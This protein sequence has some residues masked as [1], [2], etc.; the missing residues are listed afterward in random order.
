MARE[1]AKLSQ[2]CV[3]DVATENGVELLTP[4]ESSAAI[5]DPGT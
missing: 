2:V 4:G 1:A 3:P 5:P